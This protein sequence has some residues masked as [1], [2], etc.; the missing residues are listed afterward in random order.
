MVLH[1]NSGGVNGA[2]GA[3]MVLKA[4]ARPKATVALAEYPQTPRHYYY[5]WHR[6]ALDF[7]YFV[8]FA[9]SALTFWGGCADGPADQ[10]RAI[11]FFTKPENYSSP[12]S[13]I[14]FQIKK[15]VTT[16]DN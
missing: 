14:T 6:E 3:V 7:H 8:P 12:V 16:S 1:W 15:K 5:Y 11:I 13:P 2:D 10:A 9:S 4:V